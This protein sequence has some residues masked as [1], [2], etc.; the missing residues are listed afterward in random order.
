MKEERE[1]IALLYFVGWEGA[2]AVAY[3]DRVACVFTPLVRC[4]PSSDQV[5]DST[6]NAVST[7]VWARELSEGWQHHHLENTSSA[8]SNRN[9]DHE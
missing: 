5:N 9:I 7:W 3:Q 2:I 8:L 6:E 4:E 1:K